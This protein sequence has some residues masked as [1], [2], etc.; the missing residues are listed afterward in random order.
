MTPREANADLLAEI[1][2]L[3]DRVASLTRENTKL[4]EQQTATAEILRVISSSPTNV[5]AVLDTVAKSAVGL[6]EGF[7]AAIFRRDGDHLGLVAH[8]SPPGASTHSWD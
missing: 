3:R 4:Q 7:D 5:Q 1:T 2:A 6:C 8:P